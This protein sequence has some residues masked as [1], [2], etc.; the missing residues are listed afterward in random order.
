MI[1]CT[2]QGASSCADLLKSIA[3]LSLARD[4]TLGESLA[5]SSGLR[6]LHQLAVASSMT[7]ILH[8]EW[9]LR[10]IMVSSEAW[11]DYVW[12]RQR[13]VSKMDGEWCM[14]K[15]SFHGIWH[16]TSFGRSAY[17]IAHWHLCISMLWHELRW[18]Y[19]ETPL[20]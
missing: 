8:S 18:R 14:W 19:C 7:I 9:A 16:P 2:T 10:N 15:A 13:T 5:F 17:F 6:V 11:F 4:A 3:V 1:C 12:Y 20:H